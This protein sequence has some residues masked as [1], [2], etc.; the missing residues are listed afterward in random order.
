MDFLLEERRKGHIRNL[1]FSFHGPESGFKELMALHEKYHW[2]FVQIQMNYVDWTH[3]G[4]RNASA[5]FLYEELDS[6]EIPII[7]M[8]PLRG[9][10]LADLPAALADRLKEGS[11]RNLLRPGHSALPAASRE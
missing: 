9:G 1:G 10:R 5:K 4:A 6:R 3:S 11:L 7:I 2:D 8:E